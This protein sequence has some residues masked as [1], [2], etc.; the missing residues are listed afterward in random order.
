VLSA[1]RAHLYP[2][3]LL[4]LAVGDP[5]VVRPQLEALHFGPVSVVAPDHDPAEAE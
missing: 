3:Q 2:A 4:V 5:A 1:A